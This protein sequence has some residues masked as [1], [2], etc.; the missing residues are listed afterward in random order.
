MTAPLEK[1]IARLL[2]FLPYSDKPGQEAV[3]VINKLLEERASLLERCARLAENG[4]W[5]PDADDPYCGK[6]IASAIRNLKVGG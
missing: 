3:G 6:Q 5:T 1:T 2:K 4:E